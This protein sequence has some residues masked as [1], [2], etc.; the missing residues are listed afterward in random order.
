MVKKVVETWVSDVISGCEFSSENDMRE[1]DKKLNDKEW[2]VECCK[3]YIDDYTESVEI[4]EV[5]E[6]DN[7]RFEVV[8]RNLVEY[9]KNDIQNYCICDTQFHELAD[10]IDNYDDYES[11]SDFDEPIQEHL[12]KKIDEF[13]DEINALVKFTVAQQHKTT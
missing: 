4:D 2:I 1:F 12:E 5:N 10:L 11:E 7:G 3:G 8:L 13:A 9:I 6:L